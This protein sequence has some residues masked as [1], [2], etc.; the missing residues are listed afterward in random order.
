[1]IIGFGEIGKSTARRL[2]AL[3]ASVVGVRRSPGPD[4][5]ADSI[6]H[7]NELFSVLPHA[8][9]VLLCC[10]IT[11]E[12]RG[13]ANAEF[14][15]AMKDNAVLLNVGRGGLVDEPALLAGLKQGKPAYAALDVVSVE[16]LPADNPIW[17]HPKITL[18]PH[19][20]AVTEGS[21]VRTDAVFLKNLDIFLSAH[22][23]KMA[24]I[25]SKDAFDAQKD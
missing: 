4:E 23:G 15:K 8:D 11:D 9:A 12:T 18:T 1:M 6:V 20:S 13:I 2:R 19:S 14:F 16:P 17:S 22:P 24:H 25:I 5:N 7:P 10:P 3:G 21:S